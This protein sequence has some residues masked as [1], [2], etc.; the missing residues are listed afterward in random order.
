MTKFKNIKRLI[1][2]LNTDDSPVLM[3]ENDYPDALNLRIGSSDTQNENLGAETLQGEIPV[4]IDVTTEFFYYYGGAIGGQ[5]VYSGY[6]EVAIGSQTWMKKNWDG[7]YAGS[8]VYGDDEDYRAIYGGLYSWDQA[9]GMDFA[10]EGWRIPVEADIDELLTFLGGALIAGGPMKEPWTDH[11]LTPNTG[12]DNSSGFKALP[13]G[14]YDAAFDLLQEMGL[15]WLQEE[16]TPLPPIALDATDILVDAF[17]AL[18]EVSEGADGYRLDVSTSAIFASFIVGYED[19]DV[20]DVLAYEVTGLASGTAYYYRVRAY[21]DIGYGESSN[22]ITLIT[23]VADF[24]LL[25]GTAPSGLILKS[26]DDGVIFTSEGSAGVGNPTCFAKLDNEDVLYGTD[27]GYVVNYTQ[28][29]SILVDNVGIVGIASNASNVMVVTDSPN[30]KLFYSSNDGDSW[31]ERAQGSFSGSPYALINIRDDLFIF[32]TDEYLLSVENDG[33]QAVNGPLGNWTAVCDAGS[34]VIYAGDTSGH[35]WKSVNSG[36]SWSDLGYFYPNGA[37][38]IFQMVILGSGRI[39]Y[40][41]NYD[42]CYT[43]DDFVS[44]TK[45]LQF[46]GDCGN[47]IKVTDTI[48]LAV[49]KESGT[50]QADIHRSTNNGVTFTPIAGNPQQNEN[51]IKCLIQTS[52]PEGDIFDLKV[53]LTDGLTVYRKGIRGYQYDMDYSDDGGVTW[54]KSIVSINAEED[55][56]FIDI[57]SGVAEYR[58]EIRGT[59]YKIDHELTPTGFA[60]IEDTDWEN[61]YST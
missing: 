54:D 37:Y 42:W 55:S 61:I 6:E 59:A 4:L 13:G 51:V 47:A 53:T 19:L 30:Q 23:D 10:P 43:D 25:A 49:V 46:A 41:C 8:K 57:D 38:S 15:F 60:G 39:G 50:H 1:G 5:F 9:M 44:Y 21:N 45:T 52:T 31:T 32:S 11:W 3:P 56:I 33:Y 14:K 40:I 22:E 27:T 28:S 2:G 34:G 48:A 35:I 20:G 36:A 16:G 29:T 17:T 12:A 58:H 7:D 26:T 18:W 24:A